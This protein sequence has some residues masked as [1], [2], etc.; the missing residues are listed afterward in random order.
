[1]ALAA[2]C[3]QQSGQLKKSQ[4]TRLRVT[5]RRACMG[6]PRGAKQTRSES[7]WATCVNTFQPLAVRYGQLFDGVSKHLESVVH[8]SGRVVQWWFERA[9]IAAANN[10]L[11]Q[12][13]LC[14]HNWVCSNE[15]GRCSPLRSFAKLAAQLKKV[16]CWL[17]IA[18]RGVLATWL[19][20][21]ASTGSLL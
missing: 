6:H 13:R 2:G 7:Q 16:S 15:L 17:V 19:Q 4:H 18:V 3:A 5:A 11:E 14:G 21:A 9:C 12:S 1:M 10:A 20:K 8:A